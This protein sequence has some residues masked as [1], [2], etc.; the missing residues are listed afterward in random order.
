MRKV[1]EYTLLS[2]DG[3]FED[4]ARLG[5]MQY[6]DDAYL[7]DG[8]GLLLACDAMLMGRNTYESLAKIWPSRTDPWACRLNAMKKY[9]FSL[10]LKEASWSNAALVRGD[11]AAE[12]A[13]LKEEPG[14]DLLVWGHGLFSETLLRKWLIDVLDLSIHPLVIGRGKGF[15]REGQQA[16]LKLVATKSFSHIVKLTYEPQYELPASR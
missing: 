7:R 12:V 15:F 8:L 11:V 4:P 6:R 13:K 16:K 9:I 5:F 3:V 2:A 14:G 10:T 1:I